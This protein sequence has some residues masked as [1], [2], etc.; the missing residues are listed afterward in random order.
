[1]GERIDH[2]DVSLED[3]LLIPVNSSHLVRRGTFERRL[4]GAAV[5][6]W[7]H[8]ISGRTVCHVLLCQDGRTQG[9]RLDAQN[10]RDVERWIES[11]S[12]NLHVQPGRFEFQLRLSHIGSVPQ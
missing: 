2:L 12:S 4:D 8:Q 10:R 7:T 11:G 3:C 1:M 6:E 5:N 9:E